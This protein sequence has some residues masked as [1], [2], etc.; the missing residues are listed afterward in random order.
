MEK[1]KRKTAKK[2]KL[3]KQAVYENMFADFTSYQKDADGKFL[4]LIEE[5]GKEDVN[6]RKQE[7]QA[8]TDSMALL[9][10]AISDQNTAR[11]QQQ[12][13]YA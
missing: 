6:L 12:F 1:R 2:R 5:Q 4:K 10:S 3:S 9:A 13:V 11:N 8:Y 7:L